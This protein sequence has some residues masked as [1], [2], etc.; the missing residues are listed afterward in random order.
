M[1]QTLRTVIKIVLTILLVASLTSLIFSLSLYQF[2]SYKNL[3]PRL[4]YSIEQQYSQE[5]Q[6]NYSDFERTKDEITENCYNHQ[7]IDYFLNIQN[8]ATK[9]SINCSGINNETTTENFIKIVSDGIFKSVYYK[10]YDCSFINCLNQIQSNPENVFILVSKTGNSFLLNFM[11]I[12]LIISLLLISGI[13]LLS[14]FKLTCLYNLAPAFLISGLLF[15]TKNT[16]NS[17]AST[18]EGP[19]KSLVEL[20]AKT[21]FINFL[22]IFIFGAIFLI[23]TIIFRVTK[24]SEEPK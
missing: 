6:D 23:L 15:L 16:I 13:V 4:S 18:N 24:K 12:S 10:N 8:T 14:K 7:E 21:L 2:T 5:T 22:I 1:N 3:E 11:I 17:L 20:L 9:I 19:I